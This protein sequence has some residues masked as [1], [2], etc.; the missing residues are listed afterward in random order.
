[1]SQRMKNLTNRQEEILKLIKTHISDFGFPPTRADIAKTLG[2]GGHAFAAG[3]LIEG[4]L[5]DIT[6][7][8]VNATKLSVQNKMNAISR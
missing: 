4:T 2:G 7:N 6:R 3:A 8:V 5:S 1:M